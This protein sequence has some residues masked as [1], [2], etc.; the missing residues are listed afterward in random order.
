MPNREN[1][2]AAFRLLESK[3]EMEDVFDKLGMRFEYGIGPI[4][5]FLESVINEADT[6]IRNSLG[7][8]MVTE[9]KTIN[10]NG[11]PIK[12]DIDILYT[13]ENSTEWMITMDDFY[14]FLY[15]AVDNAPLREAMWKIMVEKNAAA[16]SAY[17]TA[18]A[19]GRIG[20]YPGLKD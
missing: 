14:T 7:L 8:H 18:N 16:K 3:K 15:A 2:D 9:K 6:I 1:Y 10:L 19:F 13:E 11:T 4:G 12:A 17:N 5:T 20:P